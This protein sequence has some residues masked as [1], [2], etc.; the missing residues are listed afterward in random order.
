VRTLSEEDIAAHL[1]TAGQP[2]IDLVIRT[3]GERRLSNWL[4][5]QSTG[6]EL[7]FSDKLWPDFAESDL[8]AALAEYARRER[9]FGG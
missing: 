7:I 2:D 4:L 3:S 8:L 9:R 5:W 1:Y 6:A